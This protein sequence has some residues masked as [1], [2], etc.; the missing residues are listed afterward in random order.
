MQ[1]IKTKNILYVRDYSNVLQLYKGHIF[2]RNYIN[3]TGARHKQKK[4]H[5]HTSIQIMH[6]KIVVNSFSRF[7]ALVPEFCKILKNTKK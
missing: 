5:I 4:I 7:S 6:N 1:A 2:F 3:K